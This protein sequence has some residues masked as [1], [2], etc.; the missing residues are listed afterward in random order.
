M[1]WNQIKA[2]EQLEEIKK[3]SAERKVLIFK[4]STRCTISRASLD[5]LERKWDDQEMADVKAYFLDL[6][7]F[8]EISGLIA[9][10]FNVEHE[11][12]QILL[13][14]NGKAI[15]DQSHFSIDYDQI[16]AAAKS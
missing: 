5:R 16:K 10:Q 4:H 1:K 9:Q 14:N 15:L 12:P 8:R 11:S 13:I 2:A 3:E 6:L 7:N